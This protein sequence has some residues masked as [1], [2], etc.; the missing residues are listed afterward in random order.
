MKSQE[1]LA[2]GLREYWIVDRFE[3]KVTVLRRRGDAWAESVFR[4]GQAASGLVLAGFAVPVAD[5]WAAIARV[6]DDEA[7]GA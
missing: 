7:N 3:R 6:P 1:Y 5:L 2:F 4:D